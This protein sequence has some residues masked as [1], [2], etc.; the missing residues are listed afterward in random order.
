VPEQVQS[1]YAIQG[2]AAVWGMPVAMALVLGACAWFVDMLRLGSGVENQMRSLQTLRVWI[3]AFFSVTLV[4]QAFVT[5][6]G[7]LGVMPMTG[8]PLPLLAYGRSGLLVIAVF[9]GLSMNR[10]NEVPVLSSGGRDRHV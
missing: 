7:A 8:V 1:D 2:L 10:W 9:A 6:F 5:S 4:T 3:V